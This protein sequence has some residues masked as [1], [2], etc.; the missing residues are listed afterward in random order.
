MGLLKGV[1]LLWLALLASPARAAF[2]PDPT[3]LHGYELSTDESAGSGQLIYGFGA[4]LRFGSEDDFLNQTASVHASYSQQLGRQTPGDPTTP[5]LHTTNWNGGLTLAPFTDGTVGVDLD[6]SS[7]DIDGLFTNG[8]KL[9]TG[10]KLVSISYRFAKT[11]LQE[12]FS[13]PSGKNFHGSFIYQN[14]LGA[15][16]TLPV[17]RKNGLLLSGSVSAF[18]PD[19]SGFADLLQKSVFSSLAPL[20]NQLQS[21][22]DW[23][24]RAIWRHY[25]P[26][27]FDSTVDVRYVHLVFPV[28]P[29][30]DLAV[31]AGCEVTTNLHVELGAEY[32]RDTSE[33]Q[34]LG[35]VGI[36][37]GWDRD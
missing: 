16:I 27:R 5:I 8:V 31:A 12:G 9:E 2:D 35:R 21:F 11:E 22:E 6:S 29:H 20:Q 13:I 36:R 7:D 28:N 1:P 25:F 3:P 26:Q 14:Q 34:L 24:V 15:D 33:H 17:G 19:V 18:N 37:Y 23:D 10:W 4:E 32:S 30:W